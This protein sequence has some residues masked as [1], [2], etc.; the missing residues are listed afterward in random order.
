M[1][2]LLWPFSIVSCLALSVFPD[3]AGASLDRIATSSA[4]ASYLADPPI[5]APDRVPGE[6]SQRLML[7]DEPQPFVPKRPRTEDEEDQLEAIA[8]YAAGCTLQQ[9]A[10]EENSASRRRLLHVRALRH[11][12]RAFRRDPDA[13][14][15][16]DRH[17]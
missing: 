16:A 6:P 13:A 4:F 7:D 14:V 15:A 10:K 5:P 11:L 12:Q 8:L 9:R 3:D 2:V 17:A 1:S